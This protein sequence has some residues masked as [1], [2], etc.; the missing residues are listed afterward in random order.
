[1]SGE[2]GSRAQEEEVMS[3]KADLREKTKDRNQMKVNLDNALT[4]FRRRKEGN[5]YIDKREHIFTEWALYIKKEKAAVNV[6]GSIARL[7]L[8]REVFQRIR[9][10]ARENFLDNMAEKIAHKFFDGF[11]SGLLKKAWLRWRENA[12]KHVLTDLMTAEM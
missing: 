12:K 9:L 7:T 11:K 5:V 1:M 8:R 10:A 2:E 6:I 3:L 4:A